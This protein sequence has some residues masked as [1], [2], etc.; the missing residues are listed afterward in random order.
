VTECALLEA[1]YRGL[2]QEEQAI[3][4]YLTTTALTVADRQLWHAVKAAREME[5]EALRGYLT[6]AKRAG[7]AT[8]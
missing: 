8:T 4:R 7:L 1:R 3:G 2:R 5:C 6:R